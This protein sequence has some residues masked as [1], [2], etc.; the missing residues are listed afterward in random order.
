MKKILLLIA[1]RGFQCHEYTATRTELEKCDFHIITGSDTL[2]EALG[3]DGSTQKVD[4]ELKNIHAHD[5]D[6]IFWIG[7]PGA[8]PCLDNQES[9]RIANEAMLLQKSYGAICIAPR[10]LAKA[11]VMTGKH[12]TGWD[13]DNALSQIFLENN[14]IYQRQSV[15]I[16]KNLIT[17]DGP[18][19]AEAYGAAI[20]SVLTSHDS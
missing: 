7:G 17:A 10:I 20:A 14:V 2:G 13:G 6:G 15:V 8:L 19:S 9:N 16:D 5:Y 18:Q 3:N 4:V 1:S 12:A 11:H